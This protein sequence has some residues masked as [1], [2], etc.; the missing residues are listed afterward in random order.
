MEGEV[1]MGHDKRQYRRFPIAERTLLGRLGQDHTVEIIDMSVGGAAVKAGRRFSIGS[2][3]SVKIETPYGAI[4]VQ[5]VVVRS[6]IF[7]VSE[8]IQGKRMPVYAS[9]MKF[10]EGSEERIAD[11]LCDT[12]LA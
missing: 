2:E 1:P 4:D 5:G 12:I 10:H 3:Q 6:R 8:N 7:D 9:A 11:F